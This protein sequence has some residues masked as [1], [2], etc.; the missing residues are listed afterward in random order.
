MRAG[1]EGGDKFLISLSP[2]TMMG[3]GTCVQ[4]RPMNGMGISIVSTPKGILSDRQCREQNV[5]GEVLNAVLG[6]LAPKA[7]V[8]LCGVISSYLT[9]EHPG[10]DPR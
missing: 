7:R 4:P 6:R 10:P 3:R 2:S 8:V 9:G 5:G 1:F